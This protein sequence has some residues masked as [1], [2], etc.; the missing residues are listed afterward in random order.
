[1]FPIAIESKASEIIT[2]S[3]FT[4]QSLRMHDETEINEIIIWWAWPI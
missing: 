3:P 4:H 2:I 1:M